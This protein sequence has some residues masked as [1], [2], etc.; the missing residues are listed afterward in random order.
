MSRE[1][2]NLINI[3]PDLEIPK[4]FTP[5]D[6]RGLYILF[7]PKTKED[8]NMHRKNQNGNLEPQPLSPVQIFKHEPAKPKVKRHPSGFG[9]I[10]V[11][12]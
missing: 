8:L 1:E 5:R 10:K 11:V 6:M 4:D 12:E 7:Q 9:F 2:L 3:P